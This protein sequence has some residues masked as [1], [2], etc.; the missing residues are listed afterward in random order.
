MVDPAM[1]AAGTVVA[2]QITK[3]A[4]DEFVKS[5]WR[6]GEEDRWQCNSL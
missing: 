2:G 6:S 5:G 4:I 3:I 1:V